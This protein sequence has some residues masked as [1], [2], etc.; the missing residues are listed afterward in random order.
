[1][2]SLAQFDRVLNLDPKE[3]LITVQAGIILTDLNRV[4]EENG[5]ALPVYACF[6]IFLEFTQLTKSL[7]PLGLVLLPTLL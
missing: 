1:M 6:F 2:I 7:F 3:G 4:L 5:L